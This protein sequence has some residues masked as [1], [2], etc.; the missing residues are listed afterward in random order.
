MADSQPPTK[1]RKS[2]G[3]S[4][5]ALKTNG[6]SSSGISPISPDAADSDSV[7]AVNGTTT[8]PKRVRTGCLTCRQRHLKCDEEFPVCLNCRKSN[9]ECE[10]GIRLNYIDTQTI[11]PPYIVPQSHDWQ[12]NFQDDSREI[13]S[14]YKGG[15][16]KYGPLSP[17]QFSN[18]AGDLNFDYTLAAPDIPHHSL[19]SI[20]G[21]LPAYPDASSATYSEPSNGSYQQQYAPE[22]GA[23]YPE[24]PIPKEHDEDCADGFDDQ[25]SQPYLTDPSEVLYMQVFVEEALQEPML[26]QAFLACGAR[27][28]VLVNSAYPEE[29]A[30]DYYNNATQLL[31]HS[32][33]NPERNSVLC[34]VTAVILN[35]YETMSEKALQRMNHIAGA[36]ALIKECGW[37][38][39][40][41]GI[42]G[43]CFWLN[44]GMEIHSCLHFNWLVAWEPDDWGMEMTMNP[45]QR[46]GHGVEE[47]WTHRVTY[48]LAKVA[49]FRASTPKFQEH[50]VQAEQQRLNARLQLW[51]T[52]KTMIAPNM[53]T[54]ELNPKRIVKRTNVVA[55]L[56]YHTAVALLAATHPAA[57]INPSLATEMQEM[58]ISA[59]RQICGIVAHVKDRGVASASIRCLAIAGEFTSIRREQEEILDMFAKIKKETGWKVDFL[60]QEL[61]DKWRWNNTP[62]EMAVLS[63][64]GGRSTNPQMQSYMPGNGSGGVSSKTGSQQQ[65]QQRSKPPSGIV[66]PLYRNASFEKPDHPYPQHYVA[67][68]SNHLPQTNG[69]YGQAIL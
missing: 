51:G 48:I 47:E 22:P 10:R 5:R 57:S 32:L 44:V 1:Q 50:T 8:K 13:A 33:Q 6:E 11:A 28:L 60:R 7:Q 4:K 12:V 18:A 19:P 35:V 2:L 63:F 25:S 61:I 34:A 62:D 43:A 69:L 37:N 24:P 66:N 3:S 31:L 21:M 45:E 55:N 38:A 29:K 67:P 23:K 56:F 49:N 42:G 39:K 68:A 15:A 64:L 14:E 52:L 16:A 17:D 26:K 58:K 36:R 27:H 54:R 65:Q 40:S 53:P 30:L 59:S 41:Q 9:R 46:I 20:G